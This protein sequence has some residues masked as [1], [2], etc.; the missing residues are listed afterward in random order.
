[1][2][3]L[4]HFLSI[5]VKVAISAALLGYLGYRAWNDKSFLPLVTGPKDWLVLAGAVP[6]G[7]AA[8]T[9]TILRWHMLVRALGM[10]FPL[11][12]ALRAGFLGYLFNLLP[13]GLVGGDSVKAV[14]LIQ[15]QPR[16][17][18]EAVA[19]VLVDRVIGLY[20]LLVL[21]A[22]ATLFLPLD[23]LTAL[24][25]AERAMVERLCRVVQ[26]LSLV[27]SVG[28]VVMLIPGVVHSPL[29]DILE[30]TPF[31]GP[32]L[33]KLVE[34][35]RTFRRNTGTLALAVVMSL[36]VH[37]LYVSLI[38]VLAI[39]LKVAP[40]HRPSLGM[41]FVIVPLSMM[42]GALPIGAFEITLNLLYRSVAPLGAPPNLGF[43]LALGYRVVQILI[44][45]I[46]LGYWLAGRGEVREVML[47]AEEQ[48]PA[49]KL[50][51]Q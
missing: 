13:L 24:A 48:P 27:G 23:Q 47:E 5:A 29:W 18:T 6:I 31:I 36:A 3:R 14:M 37:T 35:M 40:E 7:L 30:H 39:G 45:T 12:E 11:S 19:T 41:H 8:V 10:Q 43:L 20:A 21:S 42:S 25:A 38:V 51:V 34:A 50:E 1:M 17:K 33:H 28:L 49:G 46:G 15:H 16:R 9:L 2:S 32:V 22:I 26:I 44:A 4:K